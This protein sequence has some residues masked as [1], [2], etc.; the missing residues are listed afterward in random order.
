MSGDP[1]RD[2]NAA[3]DAIAR[4]QALLKQGDRDGA[5]AIVKEMLARAPNDADALHLS[6]V[7]A[8]RNNAHADAIAAFRAA[9]AQRPRSPRSWMALGNVL[10]RDGDYTNAAAAYREVLADEPA[11]ADATFNLGQMQ[12][13]LG[14]HDQAIRSFHAAWLADPMLFDAAK[15][16]VA[17]IA[18]LVRGGGQIALMPARPSPA[19]VDPGIFVSVVICSIEPAKLDRAVAL[20]R[21]AFAA[22][23]HE[24]IAIRDAR[25]LAEAFNWAARRSIADVLVMSHDDVD[26]LAGDFAERLLDHLRTFDAVGVVGSTRMDGPAVGWSGHPNLR[27]W[28]THRAAGEAS[29]RVDVLD[30]RPVSADI[31][32]LDGVFVAAKREV[33]RAVPYDATTFDGFHLADLD[34][35]YRASQAGFKLGVVGD[36]LLVHE[37]RGNYDATWQRYADRFSAKHA[38]GITPPAPSSFFGATLDG[39][40]QA[41]AFFE[42]LE[43]LHRGGQ[44]A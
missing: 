37:S 22:M 29:W 23:H 10:A 27:G 16:C 21:R 3:A 36:L 43:G 6:G 17:S 39:A 13:R 42:V 25:S 15:Q 1:L 28:I 20:Y 11:S 34:W 32:I 33:F 40:D 8:V 44:D 2:A 35:S 4:A 26:I 19:A 41:R 30:P 31:V 38:A 5:A 7:I 24:I 9:I 18:S 14:Q 12:K